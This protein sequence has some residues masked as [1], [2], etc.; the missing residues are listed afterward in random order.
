MSSSVG[1]SQIH[2]RRILIVEDNPIVAMGI[3]AVL[4]DL[5]CSAIVAR[6][7]AQALEQI[8]GTAIDCAILDISLVAREGEDVAETL[9]Q[10]RIP[11]VFSTALDSRSVPARYRSEPILYKPYATD[12]LIEAIE[13]TLT[14]AEI[15]AKRGADDT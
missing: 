3:E 4:A 9:K 7:S 14:V 13:A 10:R 5:G 8:E 11:F 2:N 15:T 12:E 1:P 6:R